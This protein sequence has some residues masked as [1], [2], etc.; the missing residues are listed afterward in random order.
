MVA[1]FLRG[2]K[3]RNEELLLMLRKGLPG[4]VGNY[5]HTANGLQ[6]ILKKGGLPMLPDGLVSRAFKLN[7]QQ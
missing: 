4:K 3:S 7:Q 6:N 2:A 5:W 1:P